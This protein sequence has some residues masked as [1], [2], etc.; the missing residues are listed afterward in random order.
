MYS[1]MSLQR[2]KNSLLDTPTHLYY[3][4]LTEYSIKKSFVLVKTWF[5][6]E[7]GAGVSVR[8]IFFFYYTFL[9]FALKACFLLC[10][11]YKIKSCAGSLAETP[12][13]AE[14]LPHATGKYFL[15]FL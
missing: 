3:N 9:N 2:K 13:S 5:I 14:G 4:L 11:V 7:N 8:V 6:F 15:F 1:N 10:S 12:H